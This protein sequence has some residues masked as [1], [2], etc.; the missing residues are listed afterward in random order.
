[1]YTDIVFT[2]DP[3]CGADFVKV[4]QCPPSGKCHT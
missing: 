2:F 1:M 3:Q 4:G